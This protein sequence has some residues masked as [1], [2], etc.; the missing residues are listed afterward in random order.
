VTGLVVAWAI[1]FALGAAWLARRRDRLVPAWAIF[2][3]ILGP[4]A[5]VLL[6]VAPPGRCAACRAPARGWLTQCQWCG[7]DVRT[8]SAIAVVATGAAGSPGPVVPKARPATGPNRPMI[9]VAPTRRPSDPPAPPVTSALPAPATAPVTTTTADTAKPARTSRPPWKPKAK[10][11]ETASSKERTIQLLGTG[12]YVTG[13]VGL[14]PGSRYAIQVDGVDLGIVGP[15]DRTPKA[16]AFERPLHG[17]DATGL[18]GR[19]VIS[20]PGSRGG[21]VLVF[22]SL[23]GGDTVAVAASISNAARDASG[24]QA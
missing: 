7:M 15:A 17:V 22:Q 12:I 13:T 16:V 24:V 9:S 2:G 23:D 10:T 21:T 14:T 5:L 8:G 6:W 19:L 11:S 20:A 18:E 1:A 3:A 4:V